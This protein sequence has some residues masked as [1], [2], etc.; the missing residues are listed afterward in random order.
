MKVCGQ[1][2]REAMGRCEPSCLRMR[3]QAANGHGLGGHWEG[4]AAQELLV[5]EVV[6]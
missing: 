3:V 6:P 4:A 5:Y 1:G 2:P